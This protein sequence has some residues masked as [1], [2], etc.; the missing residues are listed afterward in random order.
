MLHC[1]AGLSSVAVQSVL[2]K[3]TATEHG[4]CHGS[5][6]KVCL[7]WGSTSGQNSVPYTAMYVSDSKQCLSFLQDRDF[8]QCYVA[9]IKME[10]LV[11]VVS[12]SLVQLK[13]GFSCVTGLY[14]IL[15]VRGH[16]LKE[17]LKGTGAPPG[18]LANYKI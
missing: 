13:K 7:Q 3:C 1:G 18:N 6:R 14:F 9:F 8:S 12:V 2:A 10:H 16:V 4:I 15:F 17:C 11:C 5:E